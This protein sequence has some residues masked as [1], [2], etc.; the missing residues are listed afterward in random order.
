MAARQPHDDEAGIDDN[1]EDALAYIRRLAGGRAP[2]PELLEVYVDT[3]PAGAALPRG[4]HAAVDPLQPLP[5]YYWP[6]QFPG[7]RPMPGRTVEADPY[8]VATSCRSGPTS[9][10]SAAR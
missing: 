10:S 1:R 7:T 5:D 8:P 6:W 2:D 3:A 4:P 9:W